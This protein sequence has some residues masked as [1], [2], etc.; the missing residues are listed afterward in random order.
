VPRC[1]NGRVTTRKAND[2]LDAR[3]ESAKRGEHEVVP[4]TPEKGAVS[5]LLEPVA[6]GL[7][8]VDPPEAEDENQGGDSHRDKWADSVAGGHDRADSGGE[9][10]DGLAEQDDCE[11]PGAL[12]NVMRE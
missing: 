3:P 10:G 9:H 1:G 2:H 5:I 6:R 8:E 4:V 12:G 7:Q 11:E